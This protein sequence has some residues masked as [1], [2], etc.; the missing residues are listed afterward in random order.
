MPSCKKRIK[1]KTRFPNT[2]VIYIKFIK[3][4]GGKGMIAEVKL[5]MKNY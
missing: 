4:L 2:R 3:Y 1:I 5:D